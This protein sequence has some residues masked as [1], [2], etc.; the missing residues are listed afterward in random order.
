MSLSRSLKIAQT[1]VR[2][3]L[4]VFNP[5]RYTP[6][7]VNANKDSWIKK[8]EDAFDVVTELSLDL[9]ECVSQDE[10]Q[11]IS[12]SNEALMDEI[13]K[14]VFSINIAALSNNVLHPQATETSFDVSENQPKLD[15]GQFPTFP[16]SQCL[17]SEPRGCIP[18]SIKIINDASPVEIIQTKVE[19][20]IDVVQSVLQNQLKLVSVDQRFRGQVFNY[21]TVS[22]VLLKFPIQETHVMLQ[23]SSG[24]IQRRVDSIFTYLLLSCMG[25][26]VDCH[27]SGLPPLSSMNVLEELSLRSVA[28]ALDREVFQPQMFGDSFQHSAI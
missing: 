11:E 12:N 26:G 24:S 4:N 25:A 19:D 20:L 14:F 27:Q 28:R 2:N 13:A 15:H 17:E 1:K 22:T 8:A 9:E 10:A 6:E 5:S 23:M 3:I 7:V 21:G 18:D 16:Q